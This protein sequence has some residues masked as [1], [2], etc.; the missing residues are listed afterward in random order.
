MDD[1]KGKGVRGR[2]KKGGGETRVDT[3]HSRKITSRREV[4]LPTLALFPHYLPPALAQV[5]IL[6]FCKFFYRRMLYCYDILRAAA[7]VGSQRSRRKGYTFF[8]FS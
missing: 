8:F 3:Y 5:M 1:R 4:C 7:A 6:M 2:E